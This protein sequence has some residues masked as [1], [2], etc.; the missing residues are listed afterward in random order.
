[1]DIDKDILKLVKENSDKPL[2]IEDG[3]VVQ[4]D[5]LNAYNRF[6]EEGLVPEFYTL[7]KEGNP[8]SL[9]DSPLDK[10]MLK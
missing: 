10:N 7:D 2:V 5:F 6:I 9:L 8:T 3:N 1:M 4:E